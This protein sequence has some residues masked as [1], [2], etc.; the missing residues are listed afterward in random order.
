MT[1]PP[2]WEAATPDLREHPVYRQ[3]LLDAARALRPGE[4]QP[5]DPQD[6]QPSPNRRQVAFVGAVATALEGTPPQ[7]V[8]VLDLD[9][10]RLS[11]PFAEG[12]SQRCPRWSPCGRWLALVARPAGGA[13]AAVVP[14]DNLL[15]PKPP[16]RLM[17]AWPGAVE[18]L[19][20][21]GTQALLLLLTDAP[22][23]DEPPAAD[24]PAPGAAS[25]APAIDDGRQPAA[26][27]RRLAWWDLR[28]DRINWL[29]P[30]GLN[31]W[32]AAW[33]GDAGLVLLASDAPGEDAWY[34]AR[35]VCIAVERPAPGALPGTAQP[36]DTRWTLPT[37]PG[38]DRFALLRAAPDGRHL[39]FVQGICSDRLL[40]SGR[41]WLLKTDSGTRALVHDLGADVTNLAWDGDE[42]L[43]FAGLHGL[44]TVVARADRR[45]CTSQ[46][47]WRDTART[48]GPP[49]GPECAPWTG[50][51][52]LAFVEGFALPPALSVLGGC[53]V[54]RVLWQVPQP[55]ADEPELR[56][57]SLRWSSH[58]GLA[59]EGWLL[60]PEG[61]APAPLVVDVHGGPV[62]AHRPLW[63]GRLSSLPRRAL[64][65]AGFALLLPNPRGS[66]GR[67]QGF[68]QAVLG[69]L[70]GAEAE[71][72]LAGIDMLQARGEAGA[73]RVA[74]W[75]SSHGGFMAAWLAATS[76]RIA[77]AVAV[78]PV[79]DW[80]AEAALGPIPNFCRQF[81]GADATAAPPRPSE[82]SPLLYAQGP[83]RTAVM[84]VSGAHDAWSQ[85]EAWHRARCAA[86]HP[87]LWLHY[88]R[89]GHGVRTMPAAVDFA[90]RL[91][92]W[93]AQHAAR[94]ALAPVTL[95]AG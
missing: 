52:A 75:G 24:A 29:S 74:V 25:G 38:A 82:P 79:T 12:G 49:R 90:A 19:Q 5:S 92:L 33:C 64:L 15:D 71:D 51:G 42:A 70:G 67:G 95:R 43:L 22:G 27:W 61:K 34:S 16:M 66:S 46:P 30:A 47:L 68:A 3:A 58:D 48:V 1:A 20:W 4:G 37:P 32:E 81:Q 39:A 55:P 36:S 41:P 77:A 85:A 94:P 87:S 53:G 8:C 35:L 14:S 73:A 86:G 44:D 10:G 57:E 80:R 63:L 28:S 76:E 56:I 23:F 83:C 60:R 78:S 26:P 69:D 50:G 7:R 9:S 21:V 65:R 89:D 11:L 6:P 91:V 17:P 72:L 84:T 13:R 54:E 40:P 2:S 18:S 31:V 93:F 88:P 59:I 45:T 62:W